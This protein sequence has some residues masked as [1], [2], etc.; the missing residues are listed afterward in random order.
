MDGVDS[1]IGS[2]G[3]LER[4]EARTAGDGSFCS[5]TARG[6]IRGAGPARYGERRP[7]RRSVPMS[8]AA[9]MAPV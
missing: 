9:P 5:V 6:A 3:A 2:Y 8:S 1:V 7:S 4:A